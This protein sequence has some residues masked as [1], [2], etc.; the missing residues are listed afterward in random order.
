MYSL[1]E[2]APIFASTL[3]IVVDI[4]TRCGYGLGILSFLVLALTALVFVATIT[5]RQQREQL[6]QQQVMYKCGTCALPFLYFFPE[7]FATLALVIAA[8]IV[9]SIGGQWHW[10]VGLVVAALLPALA[11]MLPLSSWGMASD[12][13]AQQQGI[14]DVF[15]GPVGT[16][17]LAIPQAAVFAYSIARIIRLPRLSAPTSPHPSASL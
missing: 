6:A 4:R 8:A 15:L 1:V 10:F 9:A 16:A 17:L 12:P 2:L 5:A 14:M 7:L 11:S 13:A 3:A